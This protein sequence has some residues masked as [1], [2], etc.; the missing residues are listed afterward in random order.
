MDIRPIEKLKRMR[1]EKCR[2]T[3]TKVEKSH[4]YSLFKEITNGGQFN[5]NCPSCWGKAIDV[6]YKEAHPPLPKLMKHKMVMHDLK[7]Y[8]EGAGWYK[9]PDGK[10]VRG[11]DKAV[12]HLK[13]LIL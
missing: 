12:A 11:K 4:Y 5:K 7:H 10:K 6:I 3:L 8:H 2:I 1:D 9:F 13:T